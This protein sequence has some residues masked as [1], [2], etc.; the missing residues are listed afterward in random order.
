MS[1]YNSPRYL[2]LCLQALRRQNVQNFEIVV[3]DD[4]SGDETRALVE[5]HQDKASIEIK[6]VWQRDAG[7]RKTR[8]LNKSLAATHADYLIFTDGDCLA[9]PEF[10]AEHIKTSQPGTYVN[11][12][13]I[14]LNSRLTEHIKS[15]DLVHEEMFDSGW[16]RRHGEHYDRRFLRLSLPYRLRV[17][18]NHWSKTTLYWL[19]SNSSCFR[20]D[21]IAVNGFDNRFTYGYEDGDFGNR[22]ENYGLTPQT[23][24]WTALALHL[25]HEKPWSDPLEIERNRQRETP[26]EPGGR[27]KAVDG[28]EQLA[29]TDSD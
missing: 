27:Y 29:A 23:V 2:D 8:I 9:H 12:S 25:D 16:L 4:G 11:G 15:L 14:R 24:R 5:D 22:L 17:R 10:V 3:A 1:T 26:I 13:L 7:F 18:L 28:L 21:A 6:H 20:K 19:G